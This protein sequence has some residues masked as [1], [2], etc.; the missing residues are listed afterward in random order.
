MANEFELIERLRQ[1]VQAHPRLRLGI[2]DDAAEVLFG[3]QQTPVLI[4]VDMLMDQVHFDLAN[5][6][7]KLI[8]RKSLA[9][10]L[11]DIAAMGGEPVAVV[12]S[13]ALPQG[14]ADQL[15]E[16][17]H[18]GIVSLAEKYQVAVAGGDTNSWKGPLVI[19][20]T[21][22]GQPVGSHSIER[23]GAQVG[24]SLFVTGQLG[25]SLSGKHLTFEPRLNEA[26]ELVQKYDVHA[27]I[28][29]SDGLSSDLQ[30]ILRESQV[31]AVIEAESIPISSAAHQS[32]SDRSPLEQALHDGE[33]FELLFAL[34]PEEASRLQQHPELAG[35]PV[36]RIG[37][38]IEGSQAFLS[39]EGKQTLL[40]RAGWEHSL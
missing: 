6:D 17:L 29:L 9:V 27:M 12:V 7:P 15:G 4:T 31:G 40:R 30:H 39:E 26:R 21:A 28:D 5:T 13:Y 1:H 24:D 10:N 25:G 37:T 3:D 14:S 20:L 35:T 22:L 18:A 23:S 38:I 2:G 19:S 16:Q 32:G 33:D 11:S 34:S 36:T 8:G